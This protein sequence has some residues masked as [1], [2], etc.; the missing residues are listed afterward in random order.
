[1]RRVIGRLFALV[2]L[3]TGCCMINPALAAQCDNMGYSPDILE[4]AARGIM[5]AARYATLITLD[6]SGRPQARTMDPFALGDDLVVWLGTHRR[7][8]KVTQIAADPR[9]ALHYLAPDATGYVSI[10]GAAQLVDDPAEKARRWKDEWQQY[11]T[12]READ[13]ILIAVSVERLEVVD[14]SRGIAGDS[15]TWAAPA[16]CL[17]PDTLPP[18]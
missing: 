12:D 8:R 9:V 16:L 6:E 13:Y 3:A 2:L 4:A 10:N 17:R 7:S 5:E 11:Y 14:Y 18:P 15:A 1:M